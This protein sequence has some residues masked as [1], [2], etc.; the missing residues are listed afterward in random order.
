MKRELSCPGFLILA[1]VILVL[2][3]GS[4][5]SA[6]EKLPASPGIGKTYEFRFL[7]MPGK[8]K[9]LVSS[10]K[11]VDSSGKVKASLDVGSE[12]DQSG[13]H[14]VVISPDTQWGE[15]KKENSLCWRPVNQGN[16]KSQHST[17]MFT[18]EKPPAEKKYRIRITYK[19]DGEDLF[20]VEVFEGPE[21]RRIGQILL[22]N[23]GQ[24]IEEEFVIPALKVQ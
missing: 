21:F 13:P 8:T 15:R 3:A 9:A 14:R 7:I 5:V 11:I 10:I 20:P 18:L 17:F 12:E 2:S 23:S 16:G 22:E 24:W 4:M 6:D 1:S 19:D